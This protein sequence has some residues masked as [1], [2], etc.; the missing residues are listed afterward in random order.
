MAEDTADA[1]V[2]LEEVPAGQATPAVSSGL[3]GFLQALSLWMMSK[4][5]SQAQY[6][7]LVS[8]ELLV[9]LQTVTSMALHDAELVRRTSTWG[10]WVLAA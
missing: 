10:A 3:V 7:T 9:N 6:Q 1:V 4:M 2:A 8:D 5:S